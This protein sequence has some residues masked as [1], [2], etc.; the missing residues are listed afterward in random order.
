MFSLRSVLGTRTF[1]SELQGPVFGA[2]VL[3][4]IFVFLLFILR[5]L[6]RNQIAAVAVC[7]LIITLLI[8][9]ANP[10][11]FVVYLPLFTFFFVGLT[12]FGLLAFS[13]CFFTFTIFRTFPIT[14][15]GSA[16]YAG[17]GYA[18]LTILVVIVLYAFYTS[19]GGR[20]VFGTPRLDD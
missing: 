18:A 10:W 13:F 5:V 7:V 19:L 9:G 17:Y 1:L 16:W 3:T 6:R 15:D 2:I 14:L 8:S 12:R 20:P 4:F 11:L